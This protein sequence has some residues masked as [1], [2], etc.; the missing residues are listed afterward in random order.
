MQLLTCPICHRTLVNTAYRMDGWALEE[1][2]NDCPIG[3][4]SSAF[5]YGA[6]YEIIGTEHVDLDEDDPARLSMLVAEKNK[7]RKS[8]TSKRVPMFTGRGLRKRYPKGD[9]IWT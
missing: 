8:L 1:E 5:S 2:Y 9:L 7:Y 4:Y 3:H 6:Y